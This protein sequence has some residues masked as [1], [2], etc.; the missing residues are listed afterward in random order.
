MKSPKQLVLES[1]LKGKVKGLVRKAAG[2][3]GRARILLHKINASP[4]RQFIELYAGVI[5][6]K[7]QCYLGCG[8]E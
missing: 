7:M 8:D 6:K 1:A 2:K 4:A 5:D 3:K